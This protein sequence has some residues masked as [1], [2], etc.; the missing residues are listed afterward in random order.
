MFEAQTFGDGKEATHDVAQFLRFQIERRPDIEEYAV[1]VE[2]LLGAAARLK[3]ANRRE[4]FHEHAFQMRQLHDAPGF[5]AHRSDVANLGSGEQALVLGIVAGHGV[6]EINVFD[7]GHAI[8][9]EIAEAPE[10]QALP[11]H[12]MQAAEERIFLILIT[13]EM[14]SEMLQAAHA[15]ALARA[16]GGHND[17][18]DGTVKRNLIEHGLNFALRRVRVA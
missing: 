6:Q 1:P 18:P 11:H 12:G 4:G 17:A 8:D 7:R 5:I 10:M 15:R 16:S 3:Q 14:V 9:L 13:I 2:A